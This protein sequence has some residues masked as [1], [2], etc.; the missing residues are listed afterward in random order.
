MPLEIRVN[1]QADA[2]AGRVRPEDTA[3]LRRCARRALEDRGIADGELSITLLDDP[4]IARLNQQYLDR[5]GPTDVLAF[6]LNDPDQPPLGDVYVGIEQAAR[7]A[8]ELEVDLRE[9]LGRLVIHGTLHVLGYDH[10]EDD[11]RTESQMWGLQERL[12]EEALRT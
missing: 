7:Q 2:S 11:D 1:A 5:S 12:L 6:S 10:P 3:F 8:R 9:E 4:D